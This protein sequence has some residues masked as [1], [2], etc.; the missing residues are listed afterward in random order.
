MALLLIRLSACWAQKRFDL[1]SENKEFNSVSLDFVELYIYID[2]ENTWV[3]N[4]VYEILLLM[5]AV[6]VNAVPE[7]QRG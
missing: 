6:H 4:Y 3:D 1:T 7:F 2:R 5:Y